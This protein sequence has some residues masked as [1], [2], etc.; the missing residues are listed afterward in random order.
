MSNRGF[1][2]AITEKRS[3]AE[4]CAA[5]LGQGSK[6]AR[7]IDYG[8]NHS[9]GCSAGRP[10]VLAWASGHMF[11][12]APPEHYLPEA[13][14]KG[15]SFSRLPFMPARFEYL[16]YEEK[17]HDIA[18]IEKLIAGA[19]RVIHIGDPDREGQAIVDRLLSELEWHGETLRVWLSA[20]LDPKSV[21]AALAATGPNAPYL[22]LGH[23][24]E[25]R[26]KADW[27]A[28]MNYTEAYTCQ[29]RAAGGTATLTNGRVQ[30]PMLE[31]VNRREDEI[32]S[33]V[34]ADYFVPWVN[35]AATTTFRARWLGPDFSIKLDKDSQPILR[36]S[37]DADYTVGREMEG[38]DPE[39]RIPNKPLADKVLAQALAGPAR[40]IFADTS[41]ASSNPPLCL[42]TT[43]LI[44]E[45]ARVFKMPMEVANAAAAS[46]YKKEVLSYPRVDVEL[47]P[48]NALLEID[49]LIDGLAQIPMFKPMMVGLD[50]GRRSKVWSDDE[51]KLKAHHAII[52][53][54]HCTTGAMAGLTD[55]ELKIVFLTGR[56]LLMQFHAARTWTAQKVVIESPA[57]SPSQVGHRF[58]ATGRI[59]GDPGWSALTKMGLTG[60]SAEVS[61]E[62]EAETA[63]NALPA[64]LQVGAVIRLPDGGVSAEKTKPPSR[65]TDVTLIG[66]MA[67]IHLF[68]PNPEIRQ[69]LR[70]GDGLG[71]GATRV[72]IIK[73]LLSRK[74]VVRKSGFFHPTPLGRGLGRV[75]LPEHKS[76]GLTAMWERWFKSIEQGEAT[77]DQFIDSLKPWIAA[78]IKRI[79]ATPFEPL[80]D[81]TRKE[82]SP[83]A[84]HGKACPQCG[85]GQMITRE[86]K[87]SGKP[88]LSCNAYDSS[89]PDSCR[90]S[91]WPTIEPLPGTDDA[92]PTCGVGKLKTRQAASTGKRFLSCDAYDKAKPESCTYSRWPEPAPMPGH[93]QACPSCK[94]GK[95]L[96]RETKKLV[97]Y[98]SCDNWRKD[99]PSSCGHVQWTEKPV[100]P[101]DG[102][103]NQCPKCGLGLLK[104]KQ[105]QKSG[106]SYLAC[107]NWRKG[108]ATSC[109]HFAWPDRNIQK[110]PGDGDLCQACQEGHMQ[111]R[112]LDDGRRFLSC[113]GYD[114]KNPNSCRHSIWP[115]GSKKKT[116]RRGR[117]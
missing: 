96:T 44:Q 12:L 79:A 43:S 59:E 108:D 75:T 100:E 41:P 17:L 99:D 9:L 20:G 109:E 105:S 16:P 47:L 63:K 84:G 39:G 88:F 103:D 31:L 10:L 85:S 3:L 113:D 104:T 50:R 92:C 110:L 80:V 65:F 94:I 98:L 64:G 106:K 30:S 115:E 37:P 56:R 11:H 54:T 86:S 35:A 4:K 71:T 83:V 73:N 23:A 2:L 72:S 112:Q 90:H 68:E 51:A 6:S 76:A 32:T 48:I 67:R 89:K 52:P 36:P 91:E 87:K 55:D 60:A 45:A 42:S 29:N 61:E 62:D 77:E 18:A 58:A 57:H 93:G 13:Q 25:A 8:T 22:P 21:K 7:H 114:K 97:R 101:I 117:K 28:G 38:L 107:N 27:L 116:R 46:C 15:R 111:T 24:A 5:V 66:A 102:H 81:T 70:E 82:V 26:A 53:T 14:R 19:G 74:Y 40:I 34:V 33:F 69:Q 78:E 1:D 95:L 49:E